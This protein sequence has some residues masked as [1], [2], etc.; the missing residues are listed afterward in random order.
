MSCSTTNFAKGS[1]HTNY[2]KRKVTGGFY[3]RNPVTRGGVFGSSDEQ[4][5]HL[6]IGD[7]L[8]ARG[9]GS[10][11]CPRVA[12]KGGVVTGLAALQQVFDDPNCFSMQE[13]RPGFRGGFTPQFGGDVEDNSVVAGVRG[14]FSNRL[15]WDASLSHGSNAV[16]YFIYNTV[17]A[18]LGPES[19]TSFY[20]GSYKQK[21]IN[22]NFDLSY[23]ASDMVNL[24]GGAEWRNEQFEI[25]GGDKS[26]WEIG[27]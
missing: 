1:S 5:S 6:L 12:T 27:P 21:E 7:V 4:G 10:A 3:Y 20:P 13:L 14:L 25:V 24:A 11:N 19:P 23:A 2:A 16:D 18:S 8:Q 22:A 15:F 9:M 26:S 17:N